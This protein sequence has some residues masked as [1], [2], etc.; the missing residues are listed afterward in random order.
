MTG[1][2]IG[3]LLVVI[4]TVYDLPVEV[5]DTL[6]TVRF[7]I[8]PNGLVTATAGLLTVRGFGEAFVPFASADG[9]TSDE[10][11]AA[12]WKAT[13]ARVNADL[14]RSTQAAK[15]AGIFGDPS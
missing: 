13:T 7:T 8:E 14:T 6:A 5:K 1:E 15:A 10:A 3:K 9:T 4:R 2:D 11:F 12:L